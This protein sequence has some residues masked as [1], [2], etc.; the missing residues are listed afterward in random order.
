MTSDFG[1]PIVANFRVTVPDQDV[2]A[3]TAT[4]SEDMPTATPT[5]RAPVSAVQFAEDLPERN[6]SGH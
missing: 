5:R 2:I 6:L 3:C 1:P 4:S